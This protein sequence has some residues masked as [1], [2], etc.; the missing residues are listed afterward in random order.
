[1]VGNEEDFFIHDNLKKGKQAAKA[2]A[3]ASM[4]WES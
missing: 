3:R 1:M 4:V 2:A